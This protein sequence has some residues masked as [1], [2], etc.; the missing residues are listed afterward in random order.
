MEVTDT[1]QNSHSQEHGHPSDTL[2]PEIIGSPQTDQ[3]QLH[4]DASGALS[5]QHDD[6]DQ[7]LRET[8]ASLEAQLDDLCGLLDNFRSTFQ[9]KLQTFHAYVRNLP[10]RVG[11]EYNGRQRAHLLSMYGRSIRESS[12]LALHKLQQDLQ[13]LTTL[14]SSEAT[15]LYGAYADTAS[16]LSSLQPSPSSSM[17]PLNSTTASLGEQSVGSDG[18]LPSIV[19]PRAI[20]WDASSPEPGRK[21]MSDGHHEAAGDFQRPNIPW[22]MRMRLRAWRDSRRQ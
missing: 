20:T 14:G 1:A 21:S 10:D 22:R 12:E 2:G 15:S 4:E 5:S 11:V 9:T 17:A 18:V 13:R 6:P 7:A 19:P 16:L 3:P 8:I